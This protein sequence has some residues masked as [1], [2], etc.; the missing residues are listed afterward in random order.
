MHNGMVQMDAEKMAK[1]VG[2]ISLLHRALD[3]HGRDALV[4]Y[5]VSNHYR[6]PIAFSDE[7]LTEAGRAADRIRELGRRL[8]A[9]APHPGDIDERAERFFDALA[10]D[11]NTA[12]ARAVLFEWVGEANR[13]LDVGERVA[14]GRLP[15]MLHALGLEGLL[16]A[17]QEA[18]DPAALQLLEQR[19]EAR[20]ARDFERADRIRDELARTGYKVRD[21]PQGA[22]LER[23]G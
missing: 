4:M 13:R 23:P 10:E 17:S 5:L 7:A 3:E 20:A 14:P 6:H 22:R 2:N 19:E 21:T 1:S 12:A 16:E 18:P 11:F 8:D 15:E 9:G